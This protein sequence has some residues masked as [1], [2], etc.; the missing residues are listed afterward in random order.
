M[1]VLQTADKVTLLYQRDGQVRHVFLDQPHSTM[2]HRSPYG[3]SVG[4]YQGDTLVVDTIGMTADTP[5]DLFGTPHSE[6]THVVERYRVTGEGNRARLEV[7]ITV[8]DTKAFKEP[9]R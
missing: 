2:V 3:E 1:Q 4:H 5:V 9:W 6:D 7:R 8:N